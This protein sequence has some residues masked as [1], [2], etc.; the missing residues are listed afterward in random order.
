M[1]RVVPNRSWRLV[2]STCFRVSGSGGPLS[3]ARPA[4]RP[5]PRGGRPDGWDPVQAGDA[6]A[7]AG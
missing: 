3:Y 7:D 4:V 6:R 1:P 5:R 2:L